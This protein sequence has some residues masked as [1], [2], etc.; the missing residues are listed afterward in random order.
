M[1]DTRLDGRRPFLLLPALAV[2]LVVL[3][4]PVAMLLRMSLVPT[5]GPIYSGGW[6]ARHYEMFFGDPFF[7][8]VLLETVAYGLA[9][10]IGTA[11][12]GFPLAYSLARGSERTRRLR[13]VILILPLSLSLVVNVFGWMV[14]LGR[15][16]FVNSILL[17]LG[18]IDRPI[19]LLFDRPAVLVVLAHSFLPFQVL[20][21]MSVVVQIDPVLEQAAASLRASR[22]TTFRRVILPLAWPGILAGSTIVFMLTISAFVT[23]RFIGGTRVPMLG[24]LI[25]EQVLSVLN[26]PFAAAMSMLLLTIALVVAALAG[27]LGRRGAR[28]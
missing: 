23:P 5:E 2:V 16:G 4:L 20:S 17:W 21:I 1:D 9:V 15:A 14:I 8:G 7:S 3:G 24:S 12:V 19:Q 10:A 13:F 25:L 18:L 6:S 28:R 11:I 26:W 27:R 22:F